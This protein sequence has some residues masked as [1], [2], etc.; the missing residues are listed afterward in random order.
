MDI[1]DHVQSLAPT[2]SFQKKYSHI[3]KDRGSETFWIWALSILKKITEGA[4]GF[5]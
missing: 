2:G 4:K 1:G 3:P 5:C